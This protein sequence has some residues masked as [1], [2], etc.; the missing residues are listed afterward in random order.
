MPWINAFGFGGSPYQMI[1]KIFENLELLERNPETLNYLVL[2]IF[3]ICAIVVFLI[4]L[5]NNIS[6]G[7]VV[8]LHILKKIPLLFLVV[9]IILG[10][11]ELGDFAN[12]IVENLQDVV[13]IGLVLTIITSLILFIDQPIVQSFDKKN[14]QQKHS[15]TKESG[16][17]EEAN[18]NDLFN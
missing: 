12:I 9:S 7:K 6:I 15:E 4:Y 5:G 2:L 18:T 1:L 16:T 11:K 10:L 17:K 8:I 14:N 3:P 13:G